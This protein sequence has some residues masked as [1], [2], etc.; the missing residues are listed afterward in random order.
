[1]GRW[2]RACVPLEHRNGESRAATFAYLAAMSALVRV[3]TQEELPVLA[4]LQSAAYAMDAP[5]WERWQHVLALGD[6]NDAG[7][8]VIEHEGELA[9]GLG[10]Y[11]FGQFWGGRRV[12]ALGCSGVAIAPELR[13]RG[14]AATLMRET[15]C[16]AARSRAIAI[17]YPSTLHLYRSLGFESAGLTLKMEAPIDALMHGD[18]NLRMTRFDA[19][20]LTDESS[21][22]YAQVRA[23]S[24]A[25]GGHWNGTLARNA[26]IWMRVA[27]PKDIAVH[28][29]FFG[30][31]DAPEGYVIY[32]QSSPEPLH[33]N[34]TVRDYVFI[35]PRAASRWAAFLHTQ[36]ALADRVLWASGG[37]DPMLAMLAAPKAKVVEHT[38]WMLR[39]LDV[40]E[41]LTTRGYALNGEATF[42]I[43]DALLPHNEGPV[44][45]RVEGGV[46]YL[47]SAHPGAHPRL[48][49]RALSAL[50][51][52][53]QSTESLRLMGLVTCENEEAV[54]QLQSL[55][56]LFVSHPSWLP[57]FF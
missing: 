14:L 32:G 23:M 15:L 20:K 31:K 34:I 30:T 46:G 18:A 55:A 44:H 52:G 28:A 22:E 1:M 26:S 56:R 6:A 8:R 36:R 17:L 10:L 51:S 54:Q 35:T 2:K 43:T 42:E 24:E 45:L 5:S 49:I 40:E 16:E 50:Y 37:H 21:S 3:P 29:F 39:I 48:D 11:R 57:D 13:G 47:R 53:F 25:R 12:N 9:G 7:L 27:A 19:L 33:F 4:R 41:A 38:Q